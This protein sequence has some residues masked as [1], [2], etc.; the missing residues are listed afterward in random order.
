MFEDWKVTEEYV[1]RD[2]KSE[3]T[4]MSAF[5]K[6]AA[7]K[8]WHD[9]FELVTDKWNREECERGIEALEKGSY[10]EGHRYT[11]KDGIEHGYAMGWDVDVMELHDDGTV[12]GR[13]YLYYREI[14]EE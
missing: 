4:M 5:Y 8:K 9:C 10:Q 14:K 3:A 6:M 2:Y 1:I 12:T 11:D 13:I 7:N